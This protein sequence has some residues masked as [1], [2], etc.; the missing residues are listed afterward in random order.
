MSIAIFFVRYNIFLAG[1]V[2]VYKQGENK[3]TRLIK[4]VG[5]YL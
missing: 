2:F 5:R 1:R 3:K 4:L